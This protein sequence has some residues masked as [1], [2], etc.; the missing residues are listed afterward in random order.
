MLMDMKIVKYFD[1][2]LKKK[3]TSKVLWALGQ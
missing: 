2:K 1:E 3:N